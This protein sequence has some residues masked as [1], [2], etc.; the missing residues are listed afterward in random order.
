VS[1]SNYHWSGFSRPELR[2][3]PHTLQNGEER[4]VAQRLRQVLAG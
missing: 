2:L 1:P 4:V 3:H